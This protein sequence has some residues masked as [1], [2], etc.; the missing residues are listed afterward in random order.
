MA[1]KEPTLIANSSGGLD[2]LVERDAGNEIRVLTGKRELSR[3]F[4]KNLHRLSH[5]ALRQLESEPETE[6]Q[7]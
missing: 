2:L 3:K 5:E 1:K 6:N 4:W 7:E